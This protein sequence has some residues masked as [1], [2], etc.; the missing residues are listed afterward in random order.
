MRAPPV[1]CFFFEL[2]AFCGVLIPLLAH[3]EPLMVDFSRS[4]RDGVEPL[5]KAVP[6]IPG[7]GR[8]RYSGSLV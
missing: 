7:G 8:I 2:A 3:G 5:P 6:S 1:G 4:D